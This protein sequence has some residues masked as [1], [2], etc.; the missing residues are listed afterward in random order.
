MEKE[1]ENLN[2]LRLCIMNKEKKIEHEF[3]ISEYA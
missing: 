2:Y 1:P 3:V